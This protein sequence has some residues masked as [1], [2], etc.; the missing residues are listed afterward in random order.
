[1][2]INSYRH[3]YINKHI[4]YIANTIV[5]SF[6]KD[7]YDWIG[8]DNKQRELQSALKM[9][10]EQKA[11]LN[12]RIILHA[13]ETG[14]MASILETADGKLRFSETKL[15]APLTL[16]YVEARLTEFIQNPAHAKAILEYLK[17][18]RD[19]K[20]YCEINRF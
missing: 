13:K 16:K 8:M 15:H 14:K 19:I 17:K 11:A 20:T 9:L 3:S 5:M 7:I 2:I 1:M 4:N 12:S 10:R 18:K 6:E